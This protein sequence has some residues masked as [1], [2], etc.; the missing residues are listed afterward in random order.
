MRLFY[1]RYR[2]IILYVHK[3]LRPSYG[4]IIKLKPYVRSASIYIT[5]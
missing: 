5:F 3:L 2:G 1:Y 4:T